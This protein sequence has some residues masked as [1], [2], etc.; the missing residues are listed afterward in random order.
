MPTYQGQ[1]SE[2]GLIDLVEYIKTLHNNYRVQQ[3]LV[4][5]AVRP[6]GADNAGDGE[7][8]SASPTTQSSIF[9]TSARQRCRSGTTSTTSTA[10]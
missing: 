5:S 7:A 8:M 10:C 4:T 9:P 1:I 2:D 6:G 3:T